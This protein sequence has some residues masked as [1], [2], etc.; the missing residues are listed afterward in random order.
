MFMHVQVSVHTHQQILM[1]IHSLEL[2]KK[3][4]RKENSETSVIGYQ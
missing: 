4:Q 1:C 3:N 2:C